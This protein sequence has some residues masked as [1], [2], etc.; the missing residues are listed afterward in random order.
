MSSLFS[1]AEKLRCA[2]V[3]SPLL[4][5]FGKGWDLHSS[6]GNK[7]HCHP[8]RSGRAFLQVTLL[9]LRGHAVEGSLFLSISSRPPAFPCVLCVSSGWPFRPAICLS[10]ITGRGS[11]FAVHPCLPQ[12]GITSHE[13]HVLNHT[14][15]STCATAAVNLSQSLVSVSNCCLPAA[16]S[17]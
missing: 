7:S 2:S 15:P 16:V 3:G 10:R 8:D 4:C 5:G 14:L 17:S 9:G 1:P 6:S 13:L 12:A 11:R